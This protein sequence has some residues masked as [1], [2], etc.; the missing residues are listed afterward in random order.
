MKDP[1]VSVR[2]GQDLLS[3]LF[4][5]SVHCF[6]CCVC[7]LC[8]S[9]VVVHR[10]RSLRLSVASVL[11]TRNALPV[12]Y[13]CSPGAFASVVTKLAIADAQTTPVS[14]SAAFPMQRIIRLPTLVYSMEK[15]KLLPFIG[16]R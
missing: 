12:C 9:I 10:V 5:M 6:R 13:T 14:T 11:L 3:F 4:I 7:S 16:F 8:L 2:P 15:R 1:A